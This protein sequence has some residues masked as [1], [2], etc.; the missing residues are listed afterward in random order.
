MFRGVED[1]SRRQIRASA[2]EV[3]AV[4]RDYASNTSGGG[5]HRA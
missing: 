1:A 5:P 2:A 4:S 3:D